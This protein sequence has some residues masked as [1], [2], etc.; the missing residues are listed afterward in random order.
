MGFPVELAPRRPWVAAGALNLPLDWS[1]PL[2][3]HRRAIDVLGPALAQFSVACRPVIF[4]LLWMFIGA[5]SSYDA[6][7]TLK[8]ED[9]IVAMELNP[10][11]QFL[12][13]LDEGDPSLF[14]AIKFVGTLI[15]LGVLNLIHRLAPSF[16]LKMTSAVASFQACLLGFLTL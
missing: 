12:L 5:V 4:P 1:R 2:W 11:G 7:L 9:S 10:L 14:M 16:G 6:Y 15:V 13:H 8:F 3:G